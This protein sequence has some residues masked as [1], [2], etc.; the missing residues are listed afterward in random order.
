MVIFIV[1]V[2]LVLIESAKRCWQTLHGASIPEE[3]FGKPEE[4]VDVEVC[5]RHGCYGCE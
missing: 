1:G 4:L 3:A 2:I 5:E